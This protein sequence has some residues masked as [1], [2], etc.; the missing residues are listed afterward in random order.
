M[1][2]QTG[3]WTVGPE[4]PIGL[5]GMTTAVISKHEVLITGGKTSMISGINVNSTWLYDDR[6]GEFNP[7][8]DSLYTHFESTCAYIYLK[9]KGKR[10]ALCIG[11]NGNYLAEI[12]DLEFDLWELTPQFLYPLHVR[13]AFAFVIGKR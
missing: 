11:S 5:G 12:Y 4:L 10:V 13:N 9:Y 8:A 6:T 3:I 2:Y 1:D 7:R